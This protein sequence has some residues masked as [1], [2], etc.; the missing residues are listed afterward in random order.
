MCLVI[1]SPHARRYGRGCAAMHVA[2]GCSAKHAAHGWTAVFWHGA[3]HPM[4]EHA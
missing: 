1:G 3:M 2:H 4:H